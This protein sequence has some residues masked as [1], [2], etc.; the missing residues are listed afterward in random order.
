VAWLAHSLHIVGVAYFLGFL[1]LDLFV[2]RSFLDSE[3]HD[4]KLLFY[5]K[6]KK[7]LYLFV[8]II[9]ASGIWMLYLSGFN[10]R[11]HIWLKIAL[12]LF[13][14]TLFFASPYIV[15]KAGKNS[16]GYV[17]AV[18]LASVLSIVILAKI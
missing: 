16:V 9:V 6:A 8:A 4:K 13:A 1:L 11:S 7:S 12:A 3:C 5:E 17:Y 10:P 14:V 15:R 18:V 2:V